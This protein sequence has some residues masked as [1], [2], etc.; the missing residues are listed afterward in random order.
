L[1]PVWS[2]V[3]L[4]FCLLL[5]IAAATVAGYAQSAERLSQVK[6]LYIEPLGHSRGAAEIRSQIEHRLQKNSE[7]QVVSD[8]NHADAVMKGTGQIWTV[9]RSSLSPRP[10]S[11]TETV[12]QGFLS[13]EIVGRNNQTLWS[14][15]VTP[16]KFPWG[17]ISD[18]LARQLVGKLLADIKEKPPSEEA[19]ASGALANAQVALK[20]AGATFPA[21]LY[22]K[23]FESFAENH[24]G[25]HIRYDAVGSGEGI[26]RLNHGDVDFAA[27]EM[28]LSDQAISEAHQPILQLP[29]VLGAVVPIYN[30][31]AL[32]QHINFTPE[33]LAGIYLG[34]IKK[35]NDSQIRAVN[36][37]A[38]LPDAEIVVVHRSDGSGT[39]FVWSDYLSKVSPEWK[40]AVGA[41]VT[42]AWPVGTG[43]AYNEGVASAVQHT[44]N[45]LGYVEFIYALQHEVSFGAVR[46]AAGAFV[47]ADIA[48][49]TEAARNAGIPDRGLRIS[50]TDAPGKGAYPITTY[51]WL[52]LPEQ[53]KDKSKQ[54]VLLELL[55]WMLTAGQKDCSVLGYA[56]IPA[57]VARRGLESVEKIFSGSPARR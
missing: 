15:L 9:G 57:D 49:V 55:R 14:Y 54:A 30:L 24:P 42:V 45:S 33:I 5:G 53:N 11:P 52:L 50:I 8:L 4:S 3:S 16:S 38:A 31:P 26:Q 39:S 36:R 18:D 21:P 35:W 28:P 1:A 7:V 27:S 46:N 51:T 40:A 2:R 29:V 41:G 10:H 23:W 44:P 13:A 37:G 12:L 34:H 25:A 6:K 47:K 22:K 20:G 43:A 56:P 19:I 32:K 48:S 17:G